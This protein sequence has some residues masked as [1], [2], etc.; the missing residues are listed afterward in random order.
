MSLRYQ[1]VAA[2]FSMRNQHLTFH[3][4]QT[5]PACKKYGRKEA[6]AGFCAKIANFG[7]GTH[8][9]VVDP[10]PNLIHSPTL[11]SDDE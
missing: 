2:V 6:K 7:G 10:T 5:A 1:E 9:S 11:D 3:G 8:S 4:P